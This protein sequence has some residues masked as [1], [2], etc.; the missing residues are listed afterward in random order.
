MCNAWPSPSSRFRASLRDIESCLGAVPEKLYH[1]GF[2][3]PTVA[4]TTLADAR[5]APL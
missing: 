3:T 4:R 1:L 2:R 5:L